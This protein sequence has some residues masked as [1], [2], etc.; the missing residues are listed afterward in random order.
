MPVTRL[1]S[2]DAGRKGLTAEGNP[3]RSREQ[4]A[5]KRGKEGLQHLVAGRQRSRSVP[6]FLLSDSSCGRKAPPPNG[7]GD[8]DRQRDANG[9]IR[10]VRPE[11]PH[12]R[13]A[14]ETKPGA[15]SKGAGKGGAK[16]PPRQKALEPFRS[17][18]PAFGFVLRLETPHRRKALGT[19]PGAGSR[20]PGAAEQGKEGLKRLTAERHWKPESGKLRSH[21]LPRP[22]RPHRRKALEAKPG[23]G[24]S[25]AGK[26]GA[27]TPYR[28]KA[29]ETT[30]SRPGVRD[31]QSGPERPHRRKA[32]SPG[33]FRTSRGGCGAGG[34]ARVAA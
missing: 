5:A 33:R 15:G 31:S 10:W 13:K 32:R 27:E 28:R 9:C 34:S 8:T 7:T 12:R 18:F 2:P 30:G 17:C 4:G 21:I 19:K 25:E 6:A 11:R 29:L 16:T 22:E 26:G 1:R 3:G 24:S 23:A 14:P 20:E